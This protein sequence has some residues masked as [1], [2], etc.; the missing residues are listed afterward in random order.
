MKNSDRSGRAL[1]IIAHEAAQFISREAGSDS[2]I[3][4][5]RAESVAHGDRVL[6][7]VSVFPEDKTHS[8]LGF[9]ERQREAFSNHL[10]THVRLRPL[11]RVTFMPDNRVEIG[12][13]TEPLR[14]QGGN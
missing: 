2:L 14:G 1:A 6:V 8:A 5:I 13:P 10:K 3:T 7:F 9:L 4:V 11:P 12:A